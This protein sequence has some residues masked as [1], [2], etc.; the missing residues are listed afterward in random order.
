M[1]WTYEEENKERS[2]DPVPS[3]EE[4]LSFYPFLSGHVL[5]S[6]RPSSERGNRR[7]LHQET[8]SEDQ[9]AGRKDDDPVSFE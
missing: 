2:G 8:A 7:Y 3:F 5:R 6:D 1:M 9:E 4:E